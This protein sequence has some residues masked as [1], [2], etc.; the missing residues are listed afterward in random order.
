M[1]CSGKSLHIN[2]HSDCTPTAPTNGAVTPTTVI[3]GAS[4]TF[5]CETGYLVQG[6]ATATC[7]DGTVTAATCA[8]GIEIYNTSLKA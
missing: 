8:Q 7:N 1:D 6:T 4:V 5:S 2:Y 3:H